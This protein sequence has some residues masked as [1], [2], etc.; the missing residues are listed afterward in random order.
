MNTLK[1]QWALCP[2]C[3][4]MVCSGA[5][6]SLIQSV[7]NGHSNLSPLRTYRII[8]MSYG[9]RAF[10]APHAPPLSLMYTVLSDFIST[11]TSPSPK[12]SHSYPFLTPF[13]PL[14]HPFLILSPSLSPTLSPPLSSPNLLVL[15]LFI[16]IPIPNER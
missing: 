12:L 11:Q 16:P 2:S 8:R 3:T 4:Y 10:V 7:S 14:S 13:S 6:I 15:S 1:W 9:V 5:L